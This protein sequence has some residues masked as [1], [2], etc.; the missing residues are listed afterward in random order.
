[1]D[2]SYLLDYF[3]HKEHLFIVCEL[4]RDNLYEFYKFNRESGEELYF[5]LDRLRKIT[6]F[7]E[8]YFLELTIV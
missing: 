4:L 6:R 3:Y 8:S 7:E 2:I 1:M 5:T